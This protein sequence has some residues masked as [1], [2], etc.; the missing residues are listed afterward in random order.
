LCF[1]FFVFYFFTQLFSSYLSSGLNFLDVVLVEILLEIEVGELVSFRNLEELAESSVRLDVMLDF[2]VVGLD[3]VVEFLGYIGAG[4]EGACRLT[5]EAAEFIRNLGGDFKD[6]RTTLGT[7]FTF[8]ANAAFTTTSIFDFTV[9][10]LIKALDFSNHGGDGFTER[11]EGGEH[12][13]DVIIKSGGRTSRS[14]ISSNSR[15]GY[16]SRGRSSNRSRSGGGFAT[17]F[18][19]FSGSRSGYDRSNRGDRSSRGIFSLLGNTF[20]LGGGGSSSGVHYTSTGGR[21][22]LN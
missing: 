17:G 1:V 15:S 5:E 10:T 14:G 19:D 13:L 20:G 7:F 3:I 22:H 11:S 12:G 18:L 4:D 9:D 6:G 21:I 8:S 2:E 16:R